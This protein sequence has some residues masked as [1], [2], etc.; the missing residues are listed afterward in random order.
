[1]LHRSDA[2][3]ELA[4]ENENMVL[5]VLNEM[6]PDAF[7][8]EFFQ[9]LN[10]DKYYV[11]IT[12]AAGASGSPACKTFQRSFGSTAVSA[13]DA[14]AAGGDAPSGD[15]LAAPADGAAPAEAVPA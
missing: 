9:D 2:L 7:R 3:N 8:K 11:E 14:G 12:K 6:S 10:R 13:G 1:L 15:P 4:I 5:D